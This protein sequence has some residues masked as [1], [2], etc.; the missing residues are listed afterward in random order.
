MAR[1]SKLKRGRRS[2]ILIIMNPPRAVANVV[3]E[4]AQNASQQYQVA[5]PLKGT[6]PEP[7]GPGNVWVS[8]Q[9]I[10][11]GPIG[12]SEDVNHVCLTHTGRIVDTRLLIAVGAQLLGS[13][14]GFVEQ[15][16][17]TAKAQTVCRTSLDA[18]RLQTDS[19]PV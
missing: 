19:C 10:G 15:V 1:S 14:F 16:F 12:V 7:H 8:R 11:L 18:G 4:R 13:P 17:A 2:S 3:K 6:F 9:A 5:Q